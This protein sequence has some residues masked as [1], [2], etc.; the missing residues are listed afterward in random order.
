MAKLND[1]SAATAISNDDI[2][3]LRTTGG[4]DKKITGENLRDTLVTQ[5]LD[6][7][8]TQ[9]ISLSSY[10]TNLTILGTQTAPITLTITNVLNNGREFKVVNP[11]AFL[12]TV[13]LGGETYLIS[14][15]GE[16]NFTSNSSAMVRERELLTVVTGTTSYKIKKGDR[17]KIIKLAPT[18]NF[19]LTITNASTDERDYVK[20]INT[21]GTHTVS[22]KDATRTYRVYP[23]SWIKIWIDS[24][25]GLID[26]ENLKYDSGWTTPTDWTAASET[27]THDMDTEMESLEIRGFLKCD[28]FGT[29]EALFMQY[30]STGPTNYGC[31]PKAIDDDSLSLEFAS[32]A[33][34]FVF[35]TGR[36]FTAISG[37]TNPQYRIILRKN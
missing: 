7:N 34:P 15:D 8:T 21:S 20:L 9:A 24:T 28:E 26:G 30:Q 16:I 35:S 5:A 19:D 23:N 10:T 17:G 13:T 36:T 1:L 32:S 6:V 12:M 14:E 31:V 4:I 33:G 27:I 25:S 18:A 2:M 3:H 29:Q 22:V 11:T 37:L